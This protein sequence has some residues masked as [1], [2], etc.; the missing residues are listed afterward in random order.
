MFSD[1]GNSVLIQGITSEEL[2]QSIGQMI[3]VKLSELKK[4]SETPK[5]FSIQELAKASP[6]CEQTIR[7]WI[8]SG[9]L[10]A[11]KIGRRIFIEEEDFQNSLS[12]VKSLK[13]KR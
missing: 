8:I 3:D 7:N 4:H 2:L 13:Y 11:K 10:K 1:T 12:D 6:V 9:R 5:C